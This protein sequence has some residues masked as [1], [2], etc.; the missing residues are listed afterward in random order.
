MMGGPPTWCCPTW[1]ANTRVI[2]RPT[3][4]ASSVWWKGRPRSLSDVLKPG[5]TFVAKV[6]QS[7]ADATLMTQL[8]HD[9][10]TVKHVKP[11]S[12]RKDS[13]ERYVLAMGFRG[14]GNRRR[15]ES[16][17]YEE[18]HET[19]FGC[20][21][22]VRDRAARSV[23]GWTRICRRCARDDLGRFLQGLFPNWFRLSSAPAVIHLITTRGPSMGDSPEANSRPA[24]RGPSCGCRDPGWRGHR[25]TRQAG[26]G[27]CR[28]QGRTR[29]LVDRHASCAPAT[30]SRNR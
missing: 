26:I 1:P 29:P 12:S 22:V 18:F 13:S 16:V 24:Q 6:F 28:Q 10:A 5:G 20:S 15:P 17:T 3:S 8:K 30:Q 19:R 14:G 25:R 11:A 21:M 9:F 23:D 27:A 7:G 2:A 4:C